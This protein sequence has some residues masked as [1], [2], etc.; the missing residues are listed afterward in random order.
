MTHTPTPLA[1]NKI[2][3]PVYGSDG[4]LVAEAYGLGRWSKFIGTIMRESDATSIVRACNAHEGLMNL[5][6]HIV[7]MADDAYLIE[8]PEWGAIV[9]EAQAL[10]DQQ[11]GA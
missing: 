9:G 11:K 7:A 1:I 10:L 6:T 5:A 3:S 4:T 8:H 2:K